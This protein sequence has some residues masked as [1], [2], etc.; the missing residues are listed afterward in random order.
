MDHGNYDWSP[1][2]RRE[3][4]KWPEEA[5][6]ALCVI[7]N[8]EHAEWMV[9]DKAYQI[10]TLSGG[11]TPRPF[12][13]YARFSHREYGHR[14]G[15]FR[16][17][18]SLHRNGVRVTVAMDSLTACNY[19]YLVRYCLDRECEIV[20]HGVSVSRMI[21]SKMSEAVSYTHL[22]LPTKA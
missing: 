21:T 22:T 12:P 7:V 14:V 15:I 1:I 5:R 10:S 6:V 19:P 4:L 9:P 8:L 2:G 11:L 17:M 3:V 20:A 13:D 18:D 16:I